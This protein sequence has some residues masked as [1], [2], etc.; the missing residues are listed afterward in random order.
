MTRH[1][2]ERLTMRIAA[3][4]LI[5]WYIASKVASKRRRAADEL[6]RLRASRDY[7]DS[8]EKIL[9]AYLEAGI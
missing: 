2:T 1:R 9:V 5:G 8:R 4:R 6:A 7:I 3:R